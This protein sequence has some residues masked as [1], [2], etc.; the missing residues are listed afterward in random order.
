MTLPQLS[1]ARLEFA[2][3]VR[4]AEAEICL[5][6]AAFWMAAE[7]DA[8]LDL[9]V[10]LQRFETLAAAVESL[11]PA[12]RY[13]LRVVK[14]I[15][16]VLFEQEGFRGNRDRYYDPR[17]SFVPVVLQRRTG[18]PITLSL[19]YGAIA[20]RLEFPVVGIG[21]PG[22]FLMRPDFA[23]ANIFIDA[24]HEG[25][26]LFPED[27][28]ARLAQVYGRSVPLRPEFLQP[29]TKRQW[30]VRMLTNLKA[31][32]LSQND[33]AQA[34]AAV[35]R[36]L[37]VDPDLVSE[38]RDRGLLNYQLQNWSAARQDLQTYLDQAP[39]APD[40][41]PIAELL[42]HLETQDD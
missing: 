40:H 9:E 18:I 3:E 6:R 41:H 31:I 25:E 34:L 26:V 14:A 30:L 5:E 11:L 21:M 7:V 20:R 8:G 27:C 29:V 32:Y 36:I 12:E 33:F 42:E 4:Q 1:P 37:L 13:P 39:T 24:F 38:L 23:D 17:N 35:E 2:R 19:I 28:E 10:Y 16:T 15:N 22:H